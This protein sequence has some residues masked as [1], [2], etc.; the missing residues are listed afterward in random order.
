MTDLKAAKKDLFW[1]IGLTALIALI[2]SFATYYINYWPT[3]S[4]YPY[5]P[6]AAKLFELPH[7]SDIHNIPLKGVLR[8]NMHGKEALIVGIA[9]LQKALNDYITL[10]PNVLL[11]ILAVCTSAVLIYLIGLRLFDRLTAWI[12][13]LLFTFCFWPYMYIIMGAHPPLA[14]MFFL[15]AVY[16]LLISSQNAAIHIFAGVALGLMLFSTPTAPIYL[17]YYGAL[18]TYLSWK[19]L[20]RRPPLGSIAG[21]AG[22]TV[23]G[24]LVVFVIFTM[25]NIA[26]N[27]KDYFEFMQFSKLGNNFMLYKD[28]LERFFP[29][30]PSLRG[31]GWLW[32]IKYA[33]LILPVIFPLYLLAF[34]YLLKKGIDNKWLLCL[35]LL[36]LAA[37]LIVE[38][39]RVVQF[40]RNY[41][42]WYIAM[43]AVIAVG[44]HDLYHTLSPV[45][46]KAFLAVISVLIGGH[47]L[48][49][50]A[51]F[52]Q[53]IFIPRLVTTYIHDW[54]RK[55][56]VR[57]LSVYRNHF[58]F[59]NIVQFMNNPK[60]EEKV[61]FNYIESI[62]QAPS[63]YILIP[64]IT[65]KTIYVECRFDN[66][67]PDPA[68][69]E[70]FISGRL[71]EFTVARFPSLAVSRI[72]NMEEEI[73][74]YRDLILGQVTD[75][76]RRKGYALILDADKLRA[77]RNASSNI[78]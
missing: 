44:C 35:L 48:W 25:P 58:L 70:L 3:D 73:C 69:T 46:R 67:Y 59:R 18:S 23:L 62:D 66:F 12:I 68:L 47:I 16:L 2:L 45:R 6:A 14:L 19:A 32:I 33:F 5:L 22:L 55:N 21:Q 17:L 61:S 74:A 15:L 24:A 60:R 28:Y 10:F 64:P 36:S 34:F 27:I 43:L 56:D 50:L 4:E 29:V 78:E 30:H 8:V 57:E 77:A 75:E 38:A 20:K 65:G 7:I 49:N 1:V 9:I 52:R 54:C 40:G 39:S 37:P 51:V 76:D 11:L 31:G 71:D 41:F 26:G 53:E 63:G 42:S 13:Y 72:W